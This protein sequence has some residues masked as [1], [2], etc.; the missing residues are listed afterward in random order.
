MLRDAFNIRRFKPGRIIF[1][2]GSTIQAI[3]SA[4]Y[5]YRHAAEIVCISS[6]DRPIFFASYAK[7]HFPFC[8]YRFLQF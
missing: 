6:G 3:A 1:A 4:L 7:D 5:F 8:K 2:A